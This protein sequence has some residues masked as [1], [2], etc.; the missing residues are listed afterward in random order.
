MITPGH[1]TIFVYGTLMSPEVVQTLLG[2]A[3]S[4]VQ[5]ARINGFRRHPVQKKDYPGLIPI[6]NGETT[7]VL[8]QGLTSSD[9]KRLDWYEGDTYSRVDVTVTLLHD[10]SRFDT[11]VYNLKENVLQELDLTKEWDFDAF[12]KLH[13]KEY[14]EKAVQPCRDE[15]DRLGY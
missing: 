7:G 14:L 2:R 1:H 3:V 12:T 5:S 13:L 9:M 15:L 11:Q 10:S 6:A 8:L 4:N